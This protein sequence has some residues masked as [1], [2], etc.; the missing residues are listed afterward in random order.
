MKTIQ[1]EFLNPLERTEMI[2]RACWDTHS[3][4]N[5]GASAEQAKWCWSGFR[6]LVLTVLLYLRA[7]RRGLQ[8]ITLYL[9]LAATAYGYP[10]ILYQHT[11]NTDPT[12]TPENWIAAVTSGTTVGPVTDS[13]C[14][15]TLV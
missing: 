15:N 14:N 5:G 9:V 8:V 12:L 2:T 6:L 7:L 10:V 3:E 13:M 11:G 4:R 1:T